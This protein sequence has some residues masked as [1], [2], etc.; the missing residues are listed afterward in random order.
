MIRAITIKEM[1]PYIVKGQRNNLTLDKNFSLKIDTE[2]FKAFIEKGVPYIHLRTIND[3]SKHMV[4]DPANKSFI[5]YSE[6]IESN[7]RWQINYNK[8]SFSYQLVL[9]NKQNQDLYNTFAYFNHFQFDCI[10]NDNFEVLPLG[11]IN[12]EEI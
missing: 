5:R 11:S 4:I 12:I 6:D 1:I 9:A 2:F 7:Y 8:F 3:L 10:I